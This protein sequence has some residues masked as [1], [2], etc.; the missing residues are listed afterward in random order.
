V[1]APRAGRGFTL[2]EV[3]VVMVIIAVG[4]GLVSLGFDRLQ[5]DP[6][7]RQAGELSGWLQGLSDDAVLDGAVYGAWLSAD[8]ERL[9]TGYFHAGRWW[10]LAVEDGQH[11]RLVAGVTVRLADGPGW[12]A[13]VPAAPGEPS[14]QLIFEPQ[15][16]VTPASFALRGGEPPRE[17]RL[18]RD[19]N[20]LFA[21]QRVD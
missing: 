16:V 5:D 4:A 2:V 7:E 3:L 17:A 1:T 12:R 13:L 20:G 8:G 21:W 9:E 19:E 6:L 18:E 10:P 11:L 14:P 15:G